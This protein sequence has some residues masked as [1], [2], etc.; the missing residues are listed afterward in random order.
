MIFSKKTVL[1]VLGSKPTPSW[2]QEWL[3]WEVRPKEGLPSLWLK[4]N[5]WLPLWTVGLGFI[6]FAH[7]LG[8]WL[9]CPHLALSSLV[10]KDWPHFHL[11]NSNL[12]SGTE[13]SERRGGIGV[14]T[15]RTGTLM[16]GTR[17]THPTYSSFAYGQAWFL[18]MHLSTGLS[19]LRITSTHTSGFSSAS[20]KALFHTLWGW[21]WVHRWRKTATS[22]CLEASWWEEASYPIS[23]TPIE[24]HPQ[25]YSV[26][27]V[28]LRPTASESKTF[29][30]PNNWAWNLILS[31]LVVTVGWGTEYLHSL[32]VSP[33]KLLSSYQRGW[34]IEISG[35]MGQYLMTWYKWIPSTNMMSIQTWYP[36]K[37]ATAQDSN[38]TPTCKSWI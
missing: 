29:W 35:E 28:C 9:P 15:R 19:G 30:V 14:R 32:K 7:I 6:L 38:S 16:A 23:E 36:K 22:A 2:K 37:D 33:H 1:A 4:N 11:L 5:C 20:R 24:I 10:Q 31:K 3:E 17:D 12:F 18:C 13:A 26:A 25:R 8:P 21:N 34:R 27:L